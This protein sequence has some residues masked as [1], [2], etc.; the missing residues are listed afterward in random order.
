VLRLYNQ[1]HS[2]TQCLR[3][4]DVCFRVDIVTPRSVESADQLLAAFTIFE[5]SKNGPP[6]ASLGF[7]ARAAISTY[8]SLLGQRHNYIWEL[9]TAFRELGKTY[10]AG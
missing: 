4:T 2:Q 9:S 10:R 1:R 6:R 8:F 7:F 5:M 3:A